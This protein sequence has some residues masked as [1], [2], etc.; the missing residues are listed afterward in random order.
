MDGDCDLTLTNQLLDGFSHALDRI[1]FQ[2]TKH[3]GGSCFFG[4]LHTPFQRCFGHGKRDK[5]KAIHRGSGID[6]RSL[7]LSGV[8]QNLL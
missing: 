7:F 5:E 2:T 8:F 6:L 1:A 4:L 3:Q